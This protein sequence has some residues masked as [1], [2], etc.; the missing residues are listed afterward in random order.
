MSKKDNKGLVG[1]SEDLLKNAQKLREQQESKHKG[2]PHPTKEVESQSKESRGGASAF[3]DAAANFE[4]K[5]YAEAKLIPMI[6]QFVEEHKKG[7]TATIDEIKQFYND[8]LNQMQNDRRI[9]KQ[10]AEAFTKPSEVEQTKVVGK[11]FFF[12][13]EKKETTT[14]PGPSLLDE[15][16]E[17]TKKL[18]DSEKLS[19]KLGLKDKMMYGLGKLLGDNAVGNF[20]M[21]KID[22]ENLSKINN[23]EKT[24]ASAIKHVGNIGKGNEK[25][26]KS[27]DFAAKIVD[28]RTKNR[29]GGNSLG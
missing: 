10:E 17:G 9:T 5:T 11:T 27:G 24:L 13:S 4:A 6:D 18:I 22:P 26:G 29:G 3:K 1:Q 23:L 14:V 20:F 28:K 12:G 21:K 2:K 25:A 15:A 16:V 7:K 19:P 8:V